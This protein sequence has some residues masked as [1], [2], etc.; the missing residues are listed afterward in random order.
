MQHQQAGVA[1]DAAGGMPQPVAQRLGFG[2]AQLAVQQHLDPAD[3]GLGDGSHPPVASQAEPGR[4]LWAAASHMAP[5]CR[6]PSIVPA[7]S[8]DATLT[9]LG[10]A[11]QARPQP[12][13]S[14]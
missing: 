5:S 7:P 8:P 3:Q 1:G 12:P 4:P 9:A 10:G 11:A 14:P 2:E 13:V 6:A